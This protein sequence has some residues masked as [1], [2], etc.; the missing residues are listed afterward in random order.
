MVRVKVAC[1]DTSKV[2]SKRLFEMQR[3]MYL[4]QF[5]VEKRADLGEGEDDGHDN[6]NDH[7]NGEDNGMEELEHDFDPDHSHSTPKDR[8][9]NG[10]PQQHSS[11]HN[12]E[13]GSSRKVAT[14]ANLFQDEE[15]VE[16]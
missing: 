13:S 5:K 7:V 14:W 16:G 3:K 9:K 15:G 12:R 11:K 8:T 10:G 1:K 6:N 2:P 4:I